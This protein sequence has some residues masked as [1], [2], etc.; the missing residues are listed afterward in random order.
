MSVATRAFL[1]TF[2]VV[3]VVLLALQFALAPDASRRN[4]EIFTEMVYSAA[5]ESLARSE[6]LTGG[7]VQQPLLAGVVVRGMPPFRYGD[8]PEE[9]QRAG[10]EL[11]NPIAADDADALASGAELFGSFCAPCHAGTGEGAGP[12]TRRGMLPPPSLLAARALAM[13]DGEIF[14]VLTRGQGNMAS[15]AVQLSPEDRWAVILHVR[16]LQEAAR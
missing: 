15:Y 4:V 1:L 16:S 7:I 5:G 11:V 6:A 14:H 3:A 10:R 13:P 12:V 9:A 8:G 2:V